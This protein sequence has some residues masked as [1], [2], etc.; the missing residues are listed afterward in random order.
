VIDVRFMSNGEP[1]IDK[2]IVRVFD[3]GAIVQTVLLLAIFHVV[4]KRPPG[5]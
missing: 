4:S 2:N 3:V 5:A 1:R